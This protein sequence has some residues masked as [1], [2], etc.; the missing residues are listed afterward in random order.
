MSRLP[1]LRVMARATVFRFRNST[2]PQDAGRKLGVR[3]VVAGTVVR[4]GDRLTISAE[5][6]DVKTGARLW[7]NRYDRPFSD[8]V[9]VQAELASEVSAGLRLRLTDP[10]RR[11]LG[12]RGT[13]SSEAYDLYLKGRYSAIKETEEGY[14]EAIR[15]FQAAA[16]KDPGFAEAHLWAADTY[17]AMASDGYVRPAEA[18]ARS[19]EGARKALALDPSLSEARAALASRRAFFDWDFEGAEREFRE[20]FAGPRPPVWH[21]RAFALLLWARGKTEE[22]I[23]VMEGARQEDPG[24][25]ALTISSGDYRAEAGRLAEAVGLYRAAIEAEPQDPRAFFGLA[26]IF[27]SRGD[28]A[29]AIENLRRA[30]ELSGEV[31]GVKALAAARTERDYD[32]AQLAVARARLAELEAL[33]RE[34]YVSPLDIARLE[35]I[36]GEKERAFASLEAAVAERSP[37][38][39]FLN[40]D[41]AWDGIRN[42]ERFASLLKRVG[43]R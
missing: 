34:R 6:V 40:V 5:T 17:G 12:R 4:R 35:A 41:H 11:F 21:S 15:L 14:L 32:N 37:G 39:V 3:A 28:V 31:E 16:E 9:R 30:Y 18:W 2:D 42:D 23:A 10:E 38:L 25:L 1:G 24:N 7:G 33:A 26:R 36:V 29:S 43:L 22:A 19:D 27:R 20:L 13:E 8:L